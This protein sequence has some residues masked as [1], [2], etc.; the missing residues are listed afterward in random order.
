MEPHLELQLFH[1][2]QNNKFFEFCHFEAS[3]LFHEDNNLSLASLC[4]YMPL[5]F[6]CTTISQLF[7]YLLPKMPVF[8]LLPHTLS[9]L[10]LLCQSHFA[11][12]PPVPLK[13]KPSQL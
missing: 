11:P 6:Y 4:V 7:E 5:L 2:W 9:Q 3:H 8:P 10:V 1:P 13:P 12:L